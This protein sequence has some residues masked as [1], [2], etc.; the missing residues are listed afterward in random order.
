MDVRNLV[1]NKLY[2]CRDWH[3]QPSEIDR[4]PYFEFELYK[5][6][7]HKHNKEEEKRQ[8]EQEKANGNYKAPN[9]SSMMRAAQ[10]NMPKMPSTPKMPSM[11][12]F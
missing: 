6:D 10:Q 11:P 7:I 8:K 1:T 9:A 4:L 3:I 12:K 5:E 2:I